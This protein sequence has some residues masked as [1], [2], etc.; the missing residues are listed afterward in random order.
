MNHYKN[1]IELCGIVFNDCRDIEWDH[2]DDGTLWL[3]FSTYFPGD[4]GIAEEYRVIVPKIEISD[5]VV[6]KSDEGCLWKA[7]RIDE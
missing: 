6:L 3:A 5:T 2:N 4:H 1:Q 7:V